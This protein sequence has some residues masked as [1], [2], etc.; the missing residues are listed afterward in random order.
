[1][2]GLAR[3]G[4]F[5]RGRSP[6]ERCGLCASTLDPV[7]PHLVQ[8]D[9]GKL[10]C[11][12]AACAGVLNSSGGRFRRVP[13]RISLLS[14]LRMT[15]EEW[16]GFGVPVGIAFFVESTPRAGAVAFYPSPLGPVETTV[17]GGAWD[18]L[19]GRNPLVGTLQPD[20]EAL[21][22]RRSGAGS[23]AFIVPVD[24]CYRLIALVRKAWRGFTG[25]EALAGVV[26]EFFGTLRVR[27]GGVA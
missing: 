2:N 13:D 26:E 1:M 10:H 20:V 5:A 22:V 18:T 4:R 14:E 17:P 25:G 6:L 9:S 27:C 21:L 11:S 7:H 19:R 3:L 8:I 24:E 12:C 16:Q 15:A 23:E